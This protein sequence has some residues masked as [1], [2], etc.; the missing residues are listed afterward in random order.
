ME[1]VGSYRTISVSNVHGG[2]ASCSVGTGP[3]PAEKRFLVVGLRTAA[4][5][6]AVELEVV[7]VGGLLLTVVT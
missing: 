4:A 3:S 1:I 6:R 7:T 2:S 5:V